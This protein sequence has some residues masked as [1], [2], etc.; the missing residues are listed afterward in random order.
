MVVDEEILK[1]LDIDF[2]CVAQGKPDKYQD[3]PVGEDGYQD[4]FGV[5]RRKPPGS[6]YYD[7]VKSP[8]SGPITIQDILNF[9]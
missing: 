9:S 6:Y 8:L 4:E 1:A 7:L 2:R 3:I 5:I